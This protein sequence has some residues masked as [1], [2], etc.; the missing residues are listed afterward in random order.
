MVHIKNSNQNINQVQ[1]IG[2][3]D[4]IRLHSQIRKDDRSRNISL[5]SDSVKD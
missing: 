5:R 3:L 4:T 2:I 1:T